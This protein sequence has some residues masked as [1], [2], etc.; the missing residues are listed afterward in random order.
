MIQKV[1][2]NRGQILTK[3]NI[4]SCLTKARNGND[5]CRFELKFGMYITIAFFK[6]NTFD[7]MTNSRSISLWNDIQN[8][9]KLRGV[10]IITDY[11][12]R[13]IQEYNR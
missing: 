13:W 5:Y 3:D 2:L 10:I 4:S 11:V 1:K 12:F 6:D 8:L 7:V 9:R